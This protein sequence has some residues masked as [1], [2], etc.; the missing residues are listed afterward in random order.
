MLPE[1]ESP[2]EELLRLDELQPYPG[3][4]VAL[5]LLE[6]EEVRD[7]HRLFQGPVGNPEDRPVVLVPLRPPKSRQL[8]RLLN[9]VTHKVLE[10]PPPVD[11][12]AYEVDRPLRGV[13][14]ASEG[15]EL[16]LHPHPRQHHEVVPV[17]LG[18]DPLRVG[19]VVQVVFPE[20]VKFESEP[21][22]P[23]R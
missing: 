15:Q 4:R 5:V 7:L 22:G 2:D 13:E 8:E 9:L 16:G 20:V 1:Q 19:E 6:E 12:R 23:P 18:E 3:L 10:R 14:T 21:V 17:R 11:R